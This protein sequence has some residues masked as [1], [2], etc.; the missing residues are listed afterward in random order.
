VRS[1]RGEYLLHK[2][3]GVGVLSGIVLTEILFA[4]QPEHAAYYYAAVLIG[5]AVTSWIS[6]RISAGLVVP[7]Y[8]IVW[9]T[10]GVVLMANAYGMQSVQDNVLTFLVDD[11]LVLML[12][13]VGAWFGLFLRKF[14]IVRKEGTDPA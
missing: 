6:S 14:T 1:E 4:V 8:V 13:S 3:Y 12:G 2:R 9:K 5:S 10:A 7:G 11:I